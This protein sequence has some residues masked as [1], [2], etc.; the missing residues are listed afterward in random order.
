MPRMNM[1]QILPLEKYFHV[2]A[3]RNGDSIQDSIVC[4]AKI[5]NNW[6]PNKSKID[7]W[8]NG[9]SEEYYAAMKSNATYPYMLET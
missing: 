4:G 9:S 5:R 1:T 2:C 7:K 8:W 6:N 3:S